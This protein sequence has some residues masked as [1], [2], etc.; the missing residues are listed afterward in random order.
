[1]AESAHFEA[2]CEHLEAHQNEG[3]SRLQCRGIARKALNE[4]GLSTRALTNTQAVIVAG[5]VLPDVLRRNGLQDVE[6]LCRA[7]EMALVAVDSSALPEPERAP[8]DLFARLDRVLVR[9][10]KL[11]QDKGDA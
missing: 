5:R 1:M 8:E 4:A 9:S 10:R 2:L 6:T 7:I 3:W 11:T